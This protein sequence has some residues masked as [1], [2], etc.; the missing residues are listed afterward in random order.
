MLEMNAVAMADP[1]KMHATSTTQ[2][3]NM[4]LIPNAPLA[5]IFFSGVD[6]IKTSCAPAGS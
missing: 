1:S 3:Q 5:E 4:T 6:T 2:G